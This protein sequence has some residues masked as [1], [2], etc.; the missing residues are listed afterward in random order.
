M[1]GR[2]LRVGSLLVVGTAALLTG[3]SSGPSLA[4]GTASTTAPSTAASTTT[5]TTAP[6]Q[7]GWTPLSAG[8]HGIA[9]DER[10]YPQ[11]DG[12][13]VIVARFLHDHVNYGLHI[14]S[15]DP[16][17]GGAPL[18][19][20]SGPAVSAA[21]APL[22]LACFNGG[23][24]VAAQAGGTMSSGTTLVPL[25][26]GVASLVLDPTGRAQIGV[27]G[28]TV[29]TPGEQVANVRQNLPPLVLDGQPAADVADWQAWGATLGGVPRVARSALGEDASGNLL[30]AGVMAALPVDLAGALVSAGATTAMELD[31]NPGTV[32]LE[33]AA[34]PGAPLVARIP[35]Q[36][37]PADQCQVGWTRDFVTVL[38]IG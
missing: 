16:P 3:C 30:Y 5:T 23:F 15:Q 17:T 8:P 10:T 24:K 26:S 37:R 38:S 34:T 35:G 1:N 14:G 31:I 29:P 36:N 27:W 32:H 28:S 6:E 2:H 33:T 20:Q 25:R 13:Q 9:V 21:E 11:P 22:L 18:G 12:T 4:A 19:P 7:P